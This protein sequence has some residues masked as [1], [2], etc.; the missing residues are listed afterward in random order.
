MC[1]KCA[2]LAQVN[3]S[4][5]HQLLLFKGAAKFCLFYP[6][7][8]TDFH[9][10]PIAYT[11][12][13][14]E[15]PC[16]DCSLRAE[17][18]ERGIHGQDRQDFLRKRYGNSREARSKQS[19]QHYLATAKKSQEG[20][21]AAKIKELQECAKGQIKYYLGLKGGRELGWEDKGNLLKTILQVPDVFDRQALVM[22]FGSYAVWDQKDNKRKFIPHGQMTMLKAIARKANLLK[23]LET[24]FKSKPSEETSELAKEISEPSGEAVS[25]SEPPKETVLQP[26]PPKA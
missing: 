23:C 25:I 14:A 2:V 7:T 9:M 17:A 24:G 1:K 10:A 3:H 16:K 22:A 5:G 15:Y 19:A 8:E 11:S 26:E 21:D 6:H 20:V 12:R 18:T 13:P 4:C